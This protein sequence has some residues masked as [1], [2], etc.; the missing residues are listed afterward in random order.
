MP[1]DGK[2]QSKRDWRP[3]L[4]IDLTQEQYYKL[5]EL[6]PWGVRQA[7][8]NEIV[9]DVLDLLET[10]GEIAIAAVL[11]RVL[12]PREM[13][14]SIRLMEGKPDGRAEGPATKEHIGDDD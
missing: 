2:T 4:H 10:R 13:V 7:F 14:K 8:W 1:E 12:R 3:R 6:F 9:K 11:N 5:Q